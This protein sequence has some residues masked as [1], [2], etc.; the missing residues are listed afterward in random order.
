MENENL[1]KSALQPGPLGPYRRIYEP[2]P[3][4]E[5]YLFYNLQCSMETLL[6]FYDA[7]RQSNDG[8][9]SNDEGNLKIPSKDGKILFAAF[10]QAN[11][12]DLDEI[13]THSFNRNIEIS[14]IGPDDILSKSGIEY[15]VVGDKLTNIETAANTFSEIHLRGTPPLE[16]LSVAM[17]ECKRVLSRNGV[18][19]IEV[20]F[21]F[22]NEVEKSTLEGFIRETII[23]KF[24]E[25]GLVD[26]NEV[27]RIIEENFSK[28]G[29]IETKQGLVYFWAV[30]S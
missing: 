15:N 16:S 28:H 5:E 22:F 1:V 30:K 19:R 14:I 29:R 6:H 13:R 26:G 3:E 10:P 21:V 17:V 25:L 2:G 27:V 20:P 7:Y 4:A 23:N 24:P 11:V 9:E 8:S 18:L 12:R